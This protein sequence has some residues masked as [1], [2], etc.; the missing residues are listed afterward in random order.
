[1]F[2]GW[3]IVIQ[4]K[5]KLVFVLQ[6]L[7][8][9]AN[10]DADNLGTHCSPTKWRVQVVIK[11]SRYE[12]RGT[13]C[14]TLG[15]AVMLSSGCAAV[16]FGL[17]DGDIGFSQWDMAGNGTLGNDQFRMGFDTQEWFGGLDTD[18]NGLLSIVEFNAA[19]S[20][21]GWTTTHSQTGMRAAT[22]C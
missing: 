12:T 16:P 14:A 19:S 7:A 15:L 11:K 8:H 6:P 1:M 13:T 9:Y 20:G 5:H 18:D 21:W 10:G 3:L 17:G 22:G 2:L 4:K